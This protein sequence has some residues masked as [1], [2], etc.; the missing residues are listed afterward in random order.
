VAAPVVDLRHLAG[1]R[2]VLKD[3]PG[4]RVELLGSGA[5]AVVAKTYRNRG[6]RLLQTLWR[7][8]RAAREFDN[9]AAV[10]AAGIACTPPRQWS[11]VRR[12][13]CVLESTLVTSFVADTAPLKAVL[14][15]APPALRAPTRRRLAA[16]LGQL[17]L[18][19]HAAGILWATPM[20]RNVLV[21]GAAERAQLVLSDAPAAVCWPHAVPDAAVLL[22]LYDAVASPSRC[23][24]WS[25]SER[26]R[27]LLAYAAGDC[28]RART[29]WRALARRTRA[30]HR[31]RK[32]LLM[33][34]R[35]YILRRST[36][37]V[38]GAAR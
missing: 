23:R 6:L 18:R 37:A 11:A 29:L 2:T 4:A 36:T 21:A 24:D 9:L 22:D 26:M 38:R 32:N 8:P 14:A 5:D 35:T 31:L 33:A 17:L 3:E 30:G 15:A 25:R 20:P 34:L 7:R 12:L 1:P 28:A 16:E 27:C 10:A 19:L 13:G